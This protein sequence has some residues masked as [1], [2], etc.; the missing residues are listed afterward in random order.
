[1]L[2]C[3]QHWGGQGDKDRGVLADTTVVGCGTTTM[4]RG[5]GKESG[6]HCEI[7]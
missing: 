1:M 7:E 5:V 3:L 4:G 2:C 6:G